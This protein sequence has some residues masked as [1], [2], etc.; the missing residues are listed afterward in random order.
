MRPLG[1]VL[2]SPA[3]DDGSSVRHADEP[4]LIQTLVAQPAVEAFNVGIVDRL[5]NPA[6]FRA[7]MGKLVRAAARLSN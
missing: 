6:E 7:W 3:L 5:P 1:V 2:E 4:M